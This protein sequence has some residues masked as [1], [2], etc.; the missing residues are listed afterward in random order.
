M[1][2]ST[3]DRIGCVFWGEPVDHDADEDGEEASQGF[4]GL[5]EQLPD[6]HPEADDEKQKRREWVSPAAHGTW[7][8][9]MSMAQPYQS[10][11]G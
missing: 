4:L 5:M 10:D 8:F 2:L 11:N 6:H 3:L 1:Q 7:Q 9:G